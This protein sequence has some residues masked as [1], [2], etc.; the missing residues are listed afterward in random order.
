[1]P[2]SSKREYRS[3]EHISLQSVRI[4]GALN[5]LVLDVLLEQRY[6]N[7]SPR[8]IEAIYT[9]PLPAGAVLLH[10]SVLLGDKQLS[11]HIAAKEVAEATYEN[12]LAQ[13]DAAIMVEI[14]ADGSY[15]LNLGNLAANEDCTISL[16]YARMLNFEKGGLRLQI[17]TVIASRFGNP[18]VDAGLQ[19]HQVTSQ[20]INAHYPLSLTLRITEQFSGTVSSPSH[21]IRVGRDDADTVVSLAQAA[22]MDRDFI[23]VIADI[24]ATS[25][26]TS[27]AD[28]VLE[29]HFVALASFMPRMPEPDNSPLAVKIL[30]DCSGS[31]AGDSILAA[32]LAIDEIVG[33]FRAEDRFSLSRF[34][35][36]VEHAFA[37][38]RLASPSAVRLARHW[39]TS[40]K[41]D[42]GGTEMTVASIRR[43]GWALTGRQISC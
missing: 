36:T 22:S 41:A 33:R 37:R 39:T 30:V 3:D 2:S 17:P 19:P 24:E 14:N 12:A 31:M 35:S 29:G 38:P 7:Q 6:R 20:S 11:A 13:G 15:T 32:R 27:V 43:S 26:A 8:N 28:T 40:L 25:L 10:V 5:G 18:L 34:G 21:S 9:F 1:M 42:L 16:R 4:D 23:L